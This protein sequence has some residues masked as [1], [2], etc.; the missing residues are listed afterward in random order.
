MNDKLYIVWVGGVAEHE[1]Y[2]RYEAELVFRLWQ[3]RG[4]DDARIEIVTKVIA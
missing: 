3:R 1:G 2:N 4:Y